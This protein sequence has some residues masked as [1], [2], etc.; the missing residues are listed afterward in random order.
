[1]IQDGK[2]IQFNALIQFD[3]TLA[4]LELSSNDGLTFMYDR[5]DSQYEV[6]GSVTAKIN[7]TVGPPVILSGD[8]GN[9]VE[10]TDCLRRPP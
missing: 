10:P 8:F 5:A 9:A 7:K 4:S 3:F 2:L 1:M 6:Y